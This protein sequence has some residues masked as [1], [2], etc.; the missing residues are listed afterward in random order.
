MFF[1]QDPLETGTF[2][3]RNIDPVLMISVQINLHSKTYKGHKDL[4]FLLELLY[5]DKVLPNFLYICR[6]FEED[7]LVQAQILPASLRIKMDS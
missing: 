1:V 5:L 6:Y 3:L 2:V 7:C 4:L